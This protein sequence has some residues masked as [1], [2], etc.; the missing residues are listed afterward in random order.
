MLIERYWF[1]FNDDF[2]YYISLTLRM[3]NR[4]IG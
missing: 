1:G 4:K 2:R 3:T